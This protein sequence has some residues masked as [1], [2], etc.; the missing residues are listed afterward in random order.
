VQAGLILCRGR[1]GRPWVIL[2]VSPAKGTQNWLIVTFRPRRGQSTSK[3]H[4]RQG[5]AFARGRWFPTRPRRVT[6]SLAARRGLC[7]L[8]RCTG[9]NGHRLIR[10]SGT[11][12]TKRTAGAVVTSRPCA[13]ARFSWS[14]R[15]WRRH[16]APVAA[17]SQARSPAESRPAAADPQKSA[18][19]IPP[20]AA[21]LYCCTRSRTT[22]PASRPAARPGVTLPTRPPTPIAKILRQARHPAPARPAAPAAPPE[23]E[24]SCR[25]RAP[26]QPARSPPTPPQASSDDLHASIYSSA[27]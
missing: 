21:V 12:S 17:I 19:Q 11:A 10:H 1:R 25:H 6:G 9:G 13:V 4:T 26:A 14:Q 24:P 16:P 3:A 8:I 23:L 20:L 15:N 2:P 7:S 18:G 5:A 22:A 27:A